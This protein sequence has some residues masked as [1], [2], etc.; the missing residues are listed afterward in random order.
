MVR[1]NVPIRVVDWNIDRG[2]K[3]EGIID[4]LASAN[5]DLILLQEA[6]LNAK[7][8]HRDEYCSSDF[9]EVTDELCFWSG[10]SRAGA[11]FRDIAS[12]P[13]TGHTLAMAAVEF[14]NTALPK[15][16]ELLAAAVVPS[17]R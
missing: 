10:V 11:G 12:L 5:A 9:A 13:W 6:D 4:F 2:L 14:T 17:E 7:R 1:A 16:I 3:L 15:P 8:T